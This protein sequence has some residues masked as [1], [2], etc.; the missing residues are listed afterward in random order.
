MPRVSLGWKVFIAIQLIA[1]IAIV[2]CRSFPYSPAAPALW[3]AQ[4]LLLLP[5][6]WK[7]AEWVEH[8]LWSSGLSPTTIAVAALAGA[9][10]ANA[11]CWWLLLLAVRF[12]MR[13][14]KRPNHAM[15]RTAGRSA[16]RFLR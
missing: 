16:S 4:F 15:E 2:L 3:S 11:L 9:I 13:L 8:L 12:V 6:D 7:P 14:A 10:A 5:G 1:L